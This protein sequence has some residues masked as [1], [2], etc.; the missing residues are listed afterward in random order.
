MH[1]DTVLRHPPG[2]EARP[3]HFTS[4]VALTGLAKGADGLPL[5]AEDRTLLLAV[6]R[7]EDEWGCLD[8]AC[9]PQKVV[10]LYN[11][12]LFSLIPAPDPL[13]GDDPW[14]STQP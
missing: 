6:V 9:V 5:D 2:T 11:R 3:H 1:V 7:L 4:R 8:P 14:D 10:A 13:P 12:L